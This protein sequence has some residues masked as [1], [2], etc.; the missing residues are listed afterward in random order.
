MIRRMT[1]KMKN[2]RTKIVASLAIWV[3]IGASLL[4]F[5]ESK[6]TFATPTYLQDREV[7][8]TMYMD[9]EAS[10]FEAFNAQG[11]KD[12]YFPLWF[13]SLSEEKKRGFILFVRSA[14]LTSLLGDKI[15][16]T[17][18]EWLM[19]HS[20]KIAELTETYLHNTDTSDLMDQF[21][22]ISDDA[23]DRRD[24]FMEKNSWLS[25]YLGENISDFE[26]G[27]FYF[28]SEHALMTSDVEE[29]ATQFLSLNKKIQTVSNAIIGS[30]SL[31]S[32]ISPRN[33]VADEQ[34]REIVAASFFMELFYEVPADFMLLITAYET[35][36]S[37]A[38]W[39]GGQGATQQTTRAANTVLH[40]DFWIEKVQESSGAN[41]QMQMVALSSLDNVFLGISEAAKTIAIKAA[42]LQIRTKDITPNKM[43]QIAGQSLPATWATAYR[44]NGS[45]KHA[46]AYAQTVHNYYLKRKYWLQAYDSN[47]RNL[48]ALNK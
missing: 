19:A 18:E 14:A 7:L 3:V 37:L 25:S 36:F 42:E 41:I 13:N 38:F 31:K 11:V 47:D 28:F 34:I 27:L 46:R 40:S 23:A 2:D 17:D 32:R 22:A 10:V 15:G 39:E 8:N 1:I 16:F 24:I 4:L 43:V 20:N 30:R 6:K 21:T 44:Y 45:K 48:Y 29:K 35:N 12:L 26:T 5:I 33:D 9:T